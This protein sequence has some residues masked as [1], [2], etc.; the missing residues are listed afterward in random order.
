MQGL[1]TH[2]MHTHVIMDVFYVRLKV[3]CCNTSSDVF[4]CAFIF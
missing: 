1:V 3:T 2:T 4:M